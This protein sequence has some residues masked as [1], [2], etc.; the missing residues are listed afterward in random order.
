MLDLEQIY[1]QKCILFRLCMTDGC[2]SKKWK[3]NLFKKL[4][5]YGAKPITTPDPLK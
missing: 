1:K 4:L 2:H 3:A 5:E